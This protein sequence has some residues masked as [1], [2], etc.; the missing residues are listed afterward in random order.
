MSAPLVQPY[1]TYQDLC[2]LPSDG[3]RWELID[4]EA[5]MAPAPNRIRQKIVGR[6]K[7][8][9]EDSIEDSSEVYFAPLDVVFGEATAL[10]PDLIFVREENRE[11]LPDRSRRTLRRRHPPSALPAP[12]DRPPSAPRLDRPPGLYIRP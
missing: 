9:F 7:R 8:A 1:V 4:G 10:Q 5:Y 12:D 6:L 11:I 2:D 3:K